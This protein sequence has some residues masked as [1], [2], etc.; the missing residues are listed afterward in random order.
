MLFVF[1]DNTAYG[2]IGRGHDR[3]AVPYLTT[4]GERALK[5]LDK[6]PVLATLNFLNV[7]G[8]KIDELT[9]FERVKNTGKTVII[10]LDIIFLWLLFISL[11][12][13]LYQQKNGFQRS[14]L[15]IPAIFSLYFRFFL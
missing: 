6:E 11:L 3:I 12:M 13:L 7:I 2:M 14:D 9:V 15:M 8:K 5:G 4:F 1:P 10:N